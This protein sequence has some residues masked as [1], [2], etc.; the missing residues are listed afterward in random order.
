VFAYQ[1][2]TGTMCANGTVAGMGLS[3]QPGAT[4]LLLFFNGGGACWDNVSCFGLNAATHISTTYNAQVLQG[5]VAALASTGLTDRAD[6]ANPF[7]ASHMAFIPYCT[8]DLH[9]GSA[10]RTYQADLLGLDI[11]TVNHHGRANSQRFVSEIAAAFPGVTQVFL[12]GASAGGYGAML[13]HDLVTAAFPGARVDTLVDGSPFVQPQNYLYGT[14]RTQWAMTTPVCATCDMSFPALVG[15]VHAAHP[16]WRFGLI[17]S[18]NDETIRLYFGYGLNDMTPQV[19]ALVTGQYS[20]TNQHAFVVA[21]VQHVLLA[22]YRTVVGPGGVT[23]RAWVD[24]FVDGDA[25]FVT[26]RP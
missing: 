24:A 18:T 14:W 26:V 1:E 21:G 13:N 11:R 5:D 8:G 7:G 16:T 6:Q 9:A 20:G 10:V 17:T 23:L 15:A 19:N 4:S 2:V 22:G 3:A 25:G 12:V